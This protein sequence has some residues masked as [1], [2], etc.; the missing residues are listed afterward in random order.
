M[1]WAAEAAAEIK[2]WKDLKIEGPVTEKNAF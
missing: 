1:R 2:K